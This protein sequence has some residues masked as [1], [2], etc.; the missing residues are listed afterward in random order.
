MTGPCVCLS[1]VD[2]RSSDP[3]GCSA[4]IHWM[5][6]PPVRRACGVASFGF[7]KLLGTIGKIILPPTEIG[8][9]RLVKFH[10]ISRFGDSSKSIGI[11]SC[12]KIRGHT[13]VRYVDF[14]VVSEFCLFTVGSRRRIAQ[15]NRTIALGNLHQ[16]P[17]NFS[18]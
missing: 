10:F 13:S 16:M 15:I 17:S 2:V 9:D 3:I 8:G 11:R 5:L 6:Q 7:P 14:L 4:H 18:R 1:R 12:G